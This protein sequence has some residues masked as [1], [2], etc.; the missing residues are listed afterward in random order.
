MT[1]A[2]KLLRRWMDDHVGDLVALLGRIVD[3]D[4]ATENR[5]GVERLAALTADS[6][7]AL[8]FAV[9][10]VAPVPPPEPWV[11]DAFLWGRGAAAIAPGVLGRVGG[12]TGRGRLLLMAH[13]DAAFP[14]GEPARRP[15]R[16][17]G[18]RAYGPAVADMKGGVVAILFACRALLETGVARPEEI[19]VLFDTDE[20]AGTV[21]SRPLIEREARRADFGLV[22]ESGRAGGQVVGQRAGLAMGE[23]IVEGIEAHLGTGFREGRSAIETLCRK[24]TALHALQDPERGV[25]LN[26]GEI[27]GGMRRNLYAA[28]A[29]AR[30][31]I[32]T[33]DAAAWDR[34]RREV[35]GIAAREELPGTRTTLHLWQHR[36]PMPWTPKTD[37]LAALVAACADAMA[38]RIDTIATMGGSDA[39]LIAAQGTPALCGLGPVGGAIMTPGEYIEL[40]TLGERTALVASLAHLLATRGL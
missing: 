26:V 35:E 8:G 23:L 28:R 19:T 29:V 30:M 20:Q 3:M 1:D 22:T 25:L 13:L 34:V 12:G 7:A 10:R 39:N 16:I 11:N 5:E 31:D 36:P 4:T 32:R 15:F 9:E 37:A 24:V 33:V 14:P 17:E 38:T 40:P 21:C 2:V 27:A 18:A 6:L